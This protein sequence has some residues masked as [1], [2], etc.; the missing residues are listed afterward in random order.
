MKRH[1]DVDGT[2][3]LGTLSGFVRASG[4]VLSASALVDGD[5]PASI[6]RDSEVSA[7]F[8]TTTGHDHD[9]TDSKKVEWASVNSKPSTFPPS[10]HSHVQADISDLESGDSVTFGALTVGTSLVGA[11]T[12][13]HRNSTTFRAVFTEQGVNAENSAVLTSEAQKGRALALFGNGAAYFLGRDVT[14]DVEFGMGCSSAVVAYAG[15]MTNHGFELRTS[16]LARITVD[17][18]GNIGFFGVTPVARQSVASFGST[19]GTANDGLAREKCN[20]IIAALQSLGL[21]S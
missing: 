20:Q 13:G 2:L 6:A 7:Y 21:F 9:G 18:S 12:V 4:G 3:T 15:A 17:A 19:S 11:L 10:A 5:I 8:H 1:L 16:N 14:N